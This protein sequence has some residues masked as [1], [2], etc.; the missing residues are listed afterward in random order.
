MWMLACR[1][2]SLVGLLTTVHCNVIGVDL[3]SDSMKVALV[4]PGSPLEVVTNFQSKRKTPTCIS[5]YRGERMFGSDSYALMAR[6]PELTFA[7]TYRMLGRTAEHPFVTDIYKK[8]FFPYEV[9]RNEST[10]GVALKVEG[11]TFYTPEEIMAM[12]LQHARE[13]T[14][15]FGGQV[16]KDCVI[17]VP[18]H[19]TQHERRA[20]FTAAEIADLRILTLMEENTAAALHYGIDRVF[21]SPHSILYYNMGASSVQVSIVTYSS[22]TVKEPGGKN[23]SVGQFEVVGKGWDHSLGGFD[24]DVKLA[25]LLAERFNDAWHKKASGKGKDLRDFVRPMTR[26]RLEANKIKEVLSAN[27]EYP[28]KAEQLHAETDLSTKVTRAD[29]EAACESLFARITGPIDTALAMANMTLGNVNAV[30]LLGGGVRMP[31]V[32]KI[33]DEY[34]K[35][36]KIEIGQH[37][38]GDEAMALGA[39]FRAANLST[40]F[41]VRRVGLSDVS[42]FGVQ[43]QMESIAGSKRGKNGGVGGGKGLFGGLFGGGKKKESAASGGSDEDQQTEDSG[44]EWKKQTGLY[45]S[46]AAVPAKPKTVAFQH[47]QDIVCRIEYDASTAPGDLRGDALPLGTSPLLAVYNITGIA[48]FAEENSDRGLGP[49][50]IHLSFALDSSGMVFLTKAEATLEL[51]PD[52]EEEVAKAERNSTSQDATDSPVGSSSNNTSDAVY[53][54]KEKEGESVDADATD[55]G[56]AGSESKDAGSTNSTDGKDTSKKG[57]KSKGKEKVGDKK[58]LKKDRTLRRTLIVNENFD[59][60]TPSVWSAARIAEA[61]ARLR[62]LDAADKA[63]RDREAAL[64][65]LE[66]YVYKVKNVFE[67]DSKALAEVSNV[68]QRKEV[69][70][71]CSETSEWLDE[72]G[73]KPETS[74]AD[75]KAKQAAVFK[76]AEPIFSRRSELKKRPEAVK[77]STELLSSVRAAVSMWNETHPQITTNETA[78]FLEAVAAAESWIA[79]NVEAQSAKQPHEEPAFH[80]KDLKPFMDGVA[81]KMQRL[82]KKPKPKPIPSVKEVSPAIFSRPLS[83]LF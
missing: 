41:R 67:D 9:H 71:I 21:E 13:I 40:A 33:L 49:P 10:G 37:L 46:K 80:S 70:K 55:S 50:K 14:T 60:L 79:K 1:V 12:L 78:T 51:P 61:R 82:V 7:K 47:D 54:D 73:A 72:D 58:K 53:G 11:D 25:E 45:M 38:N 64:N 81:E 36:S 16:I 44:G 66:G 77:Q 24:F 69:E 56:S 26:L 19:F 62:A 29:F 32:K 15:A 35:S 52:K 34:F 28:V 5:F 17:T 59:A 42:S 2:L 3:G 6:K 8:Q 57:K 27:L 20:L 22:Y 43:V 18:S 39:A 76:A 31:R 83:V 30:E 48:E 68:E 4:A 75:F 63:R 65:D 74:V 23:K